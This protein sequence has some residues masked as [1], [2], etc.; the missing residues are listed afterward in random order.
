MKV[1]P[2]P[3]GNYPVFVEEKIDRGILS[4]SRSRGFH[5]RVRSGWYRVFRCVESLSMTPVQVPG[6]RFVPRFGEVGSRA[7]REEAQASSLT[8]D[9]WFVPFVKLPIITDA[10]CTY[11]SR[12]QRR[13]SPPPGAILAISRDRIDYAFAES[14]GL[15]LGYSD[16]TSDFRSTNFPPRYIYERVFPAVVSENSSVYYHRGSPYSGHGKPTTDQT[17][18]DIHQ[19]NVWYGSQE[20][21]HNWDKLA[22]RF[23]S[24]FGMWVL[25]R[26]SATLELAGLTNQIPSK[27]RIPQ[28]PHRRFLDGR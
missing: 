27:A 9:F 5:V 15:G 24:E 2:S 16:E 18:G 11:F 7:E 22:G 10:Q 13:C 21:W 20:P 3:Q 25:S 17:Y 8:C 28:Y 6:I 19:W 14:L 4:A 26:V 23:V 12:E 1:C